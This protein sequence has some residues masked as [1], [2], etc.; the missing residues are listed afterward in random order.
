MTKC[1]AVC[2]C[3]VRCVELAGGGRGGGGCAFA[4]QE[5]LHHAAGVAQARGELLTAAVLLDQSH[6][7]G[8]EVTPLINVRHGTHEGTQD[9]LRVVLQ[10]GG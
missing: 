1:S 2:E 9:Q 10:P 6:L 7:I 4:G 3:T 8:A 5:F